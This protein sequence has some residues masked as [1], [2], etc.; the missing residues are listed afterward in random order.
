MILPSSNI[1]LTHLNLALNKSEFNPVSLNDSMVRELAYK[2]TS[3]SSIS[4]NDVRG[5]HIIYGRLTASTSTIDTGYFAEMGG[6]GSLTPDS[7][8]TGSFT[9]FR[10]TTTNAGDAGQQILRVVF[11]APHHYVSAEDS[12]DITIWPDAGGVYRF[13]R[14]S[15]T[16]DSYGMPTW[17]RSGFSFAH[18]ASYTVLLRSS[19][20][21]T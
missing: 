11:Y 6:G 19:A 20:P 13:P 15:V 2:Q 9:I 10:L 21:S 1:A 17:P 12:L 16:I 3:G 7:P 14:G 8:G 5:K 4:L 18:N